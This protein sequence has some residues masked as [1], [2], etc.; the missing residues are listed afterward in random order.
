[1]LHLKR[2]V[3]FN[4]FIRCKVSGDIISYGDFY[5]EDDEDGFI[6]KATVYKAMLREKELNEFNY[7][8]LQRAESQLDYR[9]ALKEYEREFLA[10][11]LFERK[12]AHKEVY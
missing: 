8:K 1:M 3:N 12:I 11:S 6:V 10:Q 7:E 4:D 5:Y 2:V 9:Q